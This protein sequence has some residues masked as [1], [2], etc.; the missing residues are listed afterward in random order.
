MWDHDWAWSVPLI[1]GTLVIHVLVLARLAD[2]MR[3]VLK[4]LGPRS[5]F[6]SVFSISTGVTVFVAV[7]LLALEAF[8]WA[9]TYVHLGALPDLRR[10]MLY[11]VS[12]LTSYG[13][14]GVYLEPRWQLMGA[15]EA[16]NG[17][18]L[19]GITTAF[20]FAVVHE[21]WGNRTTGTL[22]HRSP[23]KTSDGRG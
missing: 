9:L 15:L 21:V 19:F 10:A 16:V 2:I 8:A 11:S 23:R 1:V 18:L 3:A 20:L 14:A 5:R 13:H 7:L 17:M 6:F 22:K 12:A 4:D